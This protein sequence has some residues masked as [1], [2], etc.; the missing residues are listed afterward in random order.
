METIWIPILAVVGLIFLFRSQRGKIE[1]ESGSGTGGGL[2]CGMGCCG[3]GHL[4]RKPGEEAALKGADKQTECCA[5]G[6][7]GRK[8]MKMNIL[9][10]LTMGMTVGLVALYPLEGDAMMRGGGRG[11]GSGMMGGFG[12]G[13][14][15]GGY[16]GM[17]PGGSQGMDPGSGQGRGPGMNFPG[18]VR[19]YGPP[20]NELQKPLNMN[21]ARG[22]AENY[23]KSTH[24]PN[25]HLGKIKDKGDAF[26]ANVL[27][28]DNSLVDKILIDKNTGSMRSAY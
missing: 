13:M 11:M 2:G 17:G 27:T 16:S 21:E 28:K 3:G 18:D 4:P 26:E 25:L 5:V 14:M 19:Q 1:G 12:S 24:N 10:A 6:E 20:T 7:R 23:L 8:K 9:L 15:G 22:M